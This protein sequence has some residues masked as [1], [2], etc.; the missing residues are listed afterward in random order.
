MCIGKILTKMWKTVAE[1]FQTS[2]REMKENQN[3]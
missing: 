2:L 1:N 3:K